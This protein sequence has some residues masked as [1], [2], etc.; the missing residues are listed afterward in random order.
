[1]LHFAKAEHL[2]YKTQPL[3]IR[4]VIKHLTLELVASMYRVCTKTL[5]FVMFAEHLYYN[6][7]GNS[8]NIWSHSMYDKTK[9][10]LEPCV[11]SWQESQRVHF[12]HP[13][14]EFLSASTALATMSSSP[15]EF[16]E[17]CIWRRM[18]KHVVMAAITWL[19]SNRVSRGRCKQPYS[20]GPPAH[21][22]KGGGE[23][24]VKEM[25][26]ARFKETDT[27]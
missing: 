24:E 21:T 12:P 1:M 6:I 2:R 13:M 14:V 5:P 7:W 26:K 25:W 18:S 16:G 9:S 17:D 11:V 10:W 15:A 4:V 19:L 20:H 8:I 27:C 22:P 23:R 3:N